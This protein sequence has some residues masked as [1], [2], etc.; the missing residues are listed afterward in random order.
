MRGHDSIM[1]P[2]FFS[3]RRV[4]AFL[5]GVLIAAFGAAV[6]HRDL[7]MSSAHGSAGFTPPGAAERLKAI[8]S[9]DKLSDTD[10][11]A[12]TP[13]ED[14]KPIPAP[15][16][17]DWL[18]VRK[19][20]GQTYDRFVASRPNKPSTKRNVICMQP[21]G[22]FLEDR[23]P[24]LDLL[25]KFAAA[26]FGMKVKVLPSQP[27]EKSKLTT[28]INPG[29]KKLQILAGDVLELLKGKLPADA[30]CV[31]AVTMEDLY[32]QASWNFV[33][34]MASLRERVGVF[35]FA[36]Y[37]PAFY[38]VQ[39]K[40]DYKEVLLR[41]SCKVLAH[42]AG[43]MFGIEHCVYFSCCMNGSNHLGESDSRDVHLCPM[44]LRKLQH[45]VGFDIVKRYKAL[46]AVY[47]EMGFDRES[48]WVEK[49]LAHISGDGAR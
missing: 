9:F 20:F 36:R 46:L 28:R 31:Q 49:R 34:G 3:P 40:A 19:E 29:T 22:D 37:D 6:Y 44:C 7:L 24:S 11:R 38:G 42:E 43:H 32:P 35:S 18:T 2:R 27:V 17:S 26:Y 41:R 39:R 47:K 23:S 13:G 10:R 45:V 12:F 30:Y 5:L 1:S 14:F 15:G 21:L 16:P 48:A 8:G 4:A 25:E 33:F